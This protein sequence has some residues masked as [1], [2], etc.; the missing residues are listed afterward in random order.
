MGFIE[1]KKEPL[2]PDLVEWGKVT[3]QLLYVSDEVEVAILELDVDAKIKQHT[4]W[5]T[6][7]Q[8]RNAKTGE[9]LSSVDI[10]DSHSL[11]NPTGKKM[12]VIS[13]KEFVK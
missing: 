2:H 12:S 11:A 4:H 6:K 7:E 10:G 1:E 13:I 9:V 8:Y 5:D 3:K